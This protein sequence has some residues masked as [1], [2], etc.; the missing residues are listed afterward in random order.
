MTIDDYQLIDE[1]LTKNEDERRYLNS[2]ID[3]VNERY[4]EIKEDIA[5]AFIRDLD[6]DITFQVNQHD[7]YNALDSDSASEFKIYRIPGCRKS[8]GHPLLRSIQYL[9]EHNPQIFTTYSVVLIQVT[10][11]KNFDREEELKQ[12]IEECKKLFNTDSAYIRINAKFDQ[13]NEDNLYLGGILIQLLPN[14]TKIAEAQRQEEQEEYI[15]DGVSSKDML[16]FIRKVISSY[17]KLHPGITLPELQKAL[18]RIHNGRKY[19]FVEDKNKIEDLMMTDS[20]R[21]F[22]FTDLG[23]L[24]DGTEYV[25]YRNLYSY[26]HLRKAIKFA[27]DHNII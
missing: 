27:K 21:T 26:K 14:K 6:S 3:N 17:V 15:I 23:T 2:L 5:S 19:K 10:V 25:V 1:R 20:R 7:V 9:K 24:D 4:D 12:D 16:N 8:I 13:T 18:N 11:G 22:S